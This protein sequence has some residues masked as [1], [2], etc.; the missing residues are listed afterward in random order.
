MPRVYAYQGGE[1]LDGYP[2][3][4]LATM[5]AQAVPMGA[6][7]AYRDAGGEWQWVDASDVSRPMHA[8]HDILTVYVEQ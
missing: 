8:H 7:K 5:S 4:E 6:V 2:S 1:Q 3:E